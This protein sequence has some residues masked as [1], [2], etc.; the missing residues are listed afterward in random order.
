MDTRKR[1][2]KRDRAAA[3]SEA[4]RELQRKGYLFDERGDGSWTIRVEGRVR[5]IL[6][7]WDWPMLCEFVAT[8]PPSAELA[9]KLGTR[10]E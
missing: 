9:A 5:P 2:R 3:R 8:L 7:T 6:T 1:R 4:E 10:S